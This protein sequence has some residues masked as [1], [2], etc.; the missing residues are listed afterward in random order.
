MIVEEHDW[1]DFE[2]VVLD[3][4]EALVYRLPGWLIFIN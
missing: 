2:H 3:H 1:S 4:G